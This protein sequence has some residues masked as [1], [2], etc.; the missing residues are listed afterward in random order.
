MNGVGP[1]GAFVF[2]PEL[3]IRDARGTLP[4]CF[5]SVAW[6][7]LRTARPDSIF[8]NIKLSEYRLY[9]DWKARV[10]FP[11]ALCRP[12]INLEN[13]EMSLDHPMCQPKSKR[14]DVQASRKRR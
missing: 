9:E 2:Q 8:L 10:L 4:F 3:A 6:A 5:R 12:V 14:N 7:Q 1:H 13:V 11:P